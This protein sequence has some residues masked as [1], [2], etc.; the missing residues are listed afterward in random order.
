MPFV[1]KDT[2]TAAR[3]DV[4]GPHPRENIF[5]HAKEI[6][7]DV[8]VC[9]PDGICKTSGNTTIKER[10]IPYPNRTNIEDGPN[11]KVLR[12]FRNRYPPLNVTV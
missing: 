4:G 2:V 11:V 3:N 7:I 6:V 5:K 10:Y 12:V 9:H 8:Q 1:F